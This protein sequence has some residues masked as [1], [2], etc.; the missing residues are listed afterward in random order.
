MEFYSEL[1]LPVPNTMMSD[2]YISLHKRTTESNTERNRE[3]PEPWKDKAQ[4]HNPTLTI[5]TQKGNRK[6]H[7]DGEMPEPAGN[8]KAVGVIKS[9]K[10]VRHGQEGKNKKK[11]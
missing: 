6:L 8:G 11:A 9:S 2:K 1:L 3:I 4:I 5:H 7:T 10:D